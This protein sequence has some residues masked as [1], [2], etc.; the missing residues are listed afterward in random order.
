[1]LEAHAPFVLAGLSYGN[2]VVELRSVPI[3]H[4]EARRSLEPGKSCT[5]T[6][7]KAAVCARRQ[8]YQFKSSPCPFRSRAERRKTM[9]YNAR[10]QGI[11]AIKYPPTHKSVDSFVVS[12]TRVVRI[13]MP[14]VPMACPAATAVARLSLPYWVRLRKIGQMSSLQPKGGIV[15]SENDLKDARVPSFRFTC[16][17]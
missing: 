12:A 10:P 5:E 3:I 16:P 9:E 14:S 2:T 4:I 7:V 6:R 17:C 11:D 1:M 15:T 8:A 13:S